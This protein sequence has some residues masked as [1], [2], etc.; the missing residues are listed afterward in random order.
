MIAKFLEKTILPE[1]SFEGASLE[2]NLDFRKLRSCKLDPDDR[3]ITFNIIDDIVVDAI[4]I[5]EVKHHHK[6][7]DELHQHQALHSRD[8]DTKGSGFNIHS[9]IDPDVEMIFLVFH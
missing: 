1:I 5:P 9:K 4:L 6:L 2:D 3:S 8:L 7:L